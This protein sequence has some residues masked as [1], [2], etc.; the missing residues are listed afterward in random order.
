[1]HAMKVW[2]VHFRFCIEPTKIN[3]FIILSTIIVRDKVAVEQFGY[4]SMR[5]RWAQLHPWR[6]LS[7]AELTL[8]FWKKACK[9][10]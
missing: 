5:E 8:S 9:I 6:V 3:W 7:P 10:K 4:S 1:M 2:T